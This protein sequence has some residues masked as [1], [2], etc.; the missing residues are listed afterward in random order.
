MKV[1]IGRIRDRGE[2]FESDQC[3]KVGK[4]GELLK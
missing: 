3:E 2:E 1:T 4:G